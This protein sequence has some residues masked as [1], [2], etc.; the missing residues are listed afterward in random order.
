MLWYIVV[1]VGEWR[2]QREFFNHV[3][4]SLLL[5]TYQPPKC[6]DT[7]IDINYKEMNGKITTNFIPYTTLIT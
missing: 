7:E 3:T 6:G 1:Q 4:M 5:L 2:T